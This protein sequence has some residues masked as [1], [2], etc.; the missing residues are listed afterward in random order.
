MRARLL[1]RLKGVLLGALLLVL[2]ALPFA[3]I[4]PLPERLAASHSRVVEYRDGTP[5]HVFLAEDGR[6]RMPLELDRVD[7]A[8]VASLLAL[9][10]SRFRSHPGVDPIALVRAAGTNALR[11]RRVS[12]A[13]TLTMQLVRV[14]EPRPRTYASKFVEILRALQLELRLPKDAL[15][16]AYLQF[17]PYGRNYEGLETAAW[18]YFG[19]SALHLSPAEIAALLAIPQSPGVRIPSRRNQGRLTAARDAIAKRIV[20][21]IIAGGVGEAGREEALLEEVRNTRVPLTL[22]PLPREAPHA[23]MWLI[24]RHEGARLR[25]T[26]DAGT[27]RLTE[28]LLRQ[29]REEAR[30]KGIHHGVAVVTDWHTAEVRALVGSFDFFDE[31]EGAQIAGFAVPRSPGSTLKPLL[32]ALAIDRGLANPE[33][34]VPDVPTSFDSYAPKNFDG[35]FSGLVRLEDA[36]SRSLNVPFV[37]MLKALG[38]EGFLGILRRHGVTSL[39]PAPGHYG[40]SAAVGGIA[41]SPLELAGLYTTLARDGNALPLRWIHEEER[42]EAQRIYGAGAAFLTRRALSIK[43]R[44]DFPSR[45]QL[46]G[47]PAEIHW[48][49]GTSFGHRD[50]WAVGSNASHTALVWL[51]NFDCQPSVHLT[52]ADAAGPLLFDLLEGVADRTRPIS[53]VPPSELTAIEVCAFSGHLPTEACGA[54]R[55]SQAK[56]SAVPTARCPFHQRIEVDLATGEAV[57]P[58]CRAG[59]TVEEKSVLILPATVRRFLADG[60]RELSDSPPWAKGCA[61]AE[62]HAPRIVSPV[63]NHVALLLPGVR[64]EEQEIPLEAENASFGQL[65]WFVDGVFLGTA[66]PHERM[67]WKP[68]PGVHELLVTN[69]AGQSARRRLEV[70]VRR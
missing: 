25:T 23:A 36:L 53:D 19:H 62:E 59:R 66:A 69:E 47:A 60:H 15:L 4:V 48:K 42:P 12:G 57:T 49:T 3:W 44:P 18:V 10:D 63:A 11:G 64:P 20:G 33:Q 70:R 27:Q 54:T 30:R 50:A 26:L 41:L 14:L 65:S 17:A 67:W 6:W 56:R 9:E 8:Y 45:R 24:Q 46:T 55:F 58:A 61:P 7:P 38:T 32:Y 34:L 5:A 37:S 40:L 29:A 28:R 21:A 1:R 39:E 52:G 51:G 16:T 22:R 35:E 2:L 43:D 13:S 31:K 68:A